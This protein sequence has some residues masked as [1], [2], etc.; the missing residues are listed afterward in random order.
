MVVCVSAV[1][2]GVLVAATE[3]IPQ[4]SD[5]ITVVNKGTQKEVRLDANL[6]IPDGGELL[7][8]IQ[9]PRERVVL[10]TNGPAKVARVYSDHVN[11]QFGVGEQINV[12]VE[13]TSAVDV[14]GTP[15]LFLN[16]GCRSS[17]CHVREVQRL[18]CRA[19]TGKFA[20]SFDGQRVTNIPWDASTTQFADYL[21]RMTKID[22]VLVVYRQQDGTACTYLGNNITVTFESMNIDGI[23]G[24]L[25]EMTADMSNRLGDG[26]VLGHVRF[27]PQLTTQA[28][29]IKKG[30]RVPNRVATF[31]GM[32]TP[33][34]LQF[35]YTILNGDN[36]TALEYDNTDA[37]SRSILAP[38]SA[39]RVFNAGSQIRAD[40][41][42]PPPRFSGDWERG[43]GS[44]LSA[45]SALQI[46][47]TPPYVT[48]VTSTQPD[49]TYGIGEVIIIQVVFS[50]PIVATGL[51]TIVLETGLVDRIVPFLRA[52]GATQNTLEFQYIVQSKDTSPDLTYTGT[53]ALQLNGG[54]IK[55][56]STTPT[57]DAV[58]TLPNNGERGSLS[59]SKNI[60]IDTTNPKI[61]GVS[62]LASDGTYTAG[63][64]IEI[65]V[66]FDS[67]VVVTGSPQLLLSTG[68][69]NLYPG[70]F[71]QEAPSRL[72]SKTIVF[73]TVDHGLSTAG[74]RGLQFLIDGQILTVDAVTGDAVTMLEDYTKT[75]VGP[76]VVGGPSVP[77]FTP[78]YR[79][80]TY[81]R[82]SGTSRLVF[83]YQV[84]RGDTS[85]DLDYLA[86]TSL[87][88]N[89]G[90]IKRLSTT[91]FTDVDLT[92]AAPGSTGSLGLSAA[93]VINTNA[94][95]VIQANLLTRD[96]VYRVGDEIL[97]S[98]VFDL[99]VVVDQ[100][101]SVRMNVVHPATERSAVYLSGSGTSALVFRF[102]CDPN[103]QATVFDIAD[104]TSLRASFGSIFGYIRRLAMNP[105]LPAVLNLPI[106]GLSSKGI[107]IDQ[108]CAFVNSVSVARADGAVGAGEIIQFTVQYSATVNVDITN[109][110][111]SL[112]L[113]TQRRATYLSGTGSQSLT[114]QYT[115]AVDDPTTR[116]N[117]AD[118][119]SLQLNG[120]QI[121]ATGTGKPASTVL[122]A[123]STS[124]LA[125]TSRITID[126]TTPVVL[127]VLT[128]TLDDVYTVGDRLIVVVRMNSPIDV[129]SSSGRGTLT[130][131]LQLGL[132][133]GVPAS[134]VS[135]EADRM[136]FAWTVSSG[137]S[138]MRLAYRSRTSLRCIGNYGL[139]TNAV[140]NNAITPHGVEYQGRL[141]VIWSERSS[142]VGGVAQLRARSTLISDTVAPLWQQE[143][144]DGVTSLIQFNAAMS[145][146]APMLVAFS[147]TK[148]YACW[149]ELS[150]PTANTPSQIRVAAYL[151]GDPT[152]TQ[153]WAFVDRQPATA[154]G[155]NLDTTQNAAAP[156]MVVHSG[157]LYVAWHEVSA[158]TTTTQIRV[159]VYGGQD[160]APTWTFV[161]GNLAARGLNYASTQN[162]QNV[163]L[164]SCNGALHAAWEEVNAAGVSQIRVAVQRGTDVSP[165]W[166]FMDG[167]SASGLNIAATQGANVP[168]LACLGDSSLAVAWHESV[169]VNAALKTRIR[170][171][172]TTT[173]ITATTFTWATVDGGNGLNVDASQ[174]GQNVR[175][176]VLSQLSGSVLY[177]SWEETE[178]TS[179][180][181]QT[182]DVFNKA[183]V[184][185]GQY[186]LAYGDDTTVCIDWNAA[187]TGTGSLQ[188]ALQSISG[189]SLQAT[190]TDDTN[191]FH[192]GVRYTITFT[193]PTT[194]LRA[195]RL[196]DTADAGCAAWT[197]QPGTALLACNSGTLVRV[198]ENKNIPL[199]S[200]IVDINVRFSTSVMVKTGIPRL[201]LE[202]GAVDQDAIYSIRGVLREFDVGTTSP[203]FVLRGA[204]RL[205]YGDVSA[206]INTLTTTECINIAF[207]NDDDAVQEIQSKLL[208]LPALRTIGLR[209][210]RR[211]I[212]RNGYRYSILFRSSA[213]LLDLVPVD[214]SACTPFAGRVQTI[215]V[216]ADTPII[217]GE[218]QILFGDGITGCVPVKANSQTIEDTISSMIPNRITPIQ[219]VK[220]PSAY[221]FGHR[222]FVSFMLLSDAVQ[223]LRVLIGGALCVPFLCDD[224]NG[225]AGTCSGLSITTNARYQAIRAE[226][227]TLSFRYVIQPADSQTPLTVRDST[228]LSGQ[229][230]RSSMNP[231]LAAAL[232]LPP[233]TP[234]PIEVISVQAIP[235]VTRVYSSTLN[236]VYTAGDMLVVLVEFSLPVDVIGKPFLELNSNGAAMFYSGS[237]TTTLEFRYKILPGE[238]T[239]DLNY[240]SIYSLRTPGRFIFIQATDGI[241]ARSSPIEADLTL[242][243]LTDA[244]SLG[245]QHQLVI[246][247]TTPSIVS[248][249][250]SRPDSPAGSTGY[251]VGD[252]IDLVVE[253]S[254]EISVSGLPSLALNSGGVATFTYGGYRQL[255]DIG[256]HAVYPVTSG[257][258]AVSYKGRT[259]G[260]ID[261]GDAQS[262]AITS[263]KSQLLTYDELRAIGITSVVMSTKK[264]GHRFEITFDST[265][266]L[267]VPEPVLPAS[268][269]VCA[270]LLPSSSDST[271]ERLLEQATDQ[272]AVFHYHVGEGNI[273]ADLDTTGVGVDL[274]LNPNSAIQR[275][276]RRP[277]ID[278]DVTLPV[279]GS[280]GSL[281]VRKT[282]KVDGSP[283]VI[284]DIISDTAGGTYGVS[285]PPIASPA[286]VFPGEILFHL[287]FSR[288]VKV[289]GSPTLELATGSLQSN[290]T[291][292]PNR[293]AR[294]VGQPQPDQ[295]AFLYHIQEGDFSANLAFASVNA[296]TNAQIYCVSTSSTTMAH[297]T[298]PRL[299]VSTTSTL[300]VDAQSVPTTVKL[301]ST[302]PNGVVGA[303]EAIPIQVT[304]SKQVILQTGLNRQQAS[305]ARYPCAVEFE[306]NLYVFWTEWTTLEMRPTTR[307]ALY[308]RVFDAAMQEVT[309]TARQQ[310]AMNRYSSSFI[311]KVT[312]TVWMGQ[313]Y[314]AWD[315]NGELLCTVFSGLTAAAGVAPWT[316]VPR[317]GAN[318][319]LAMRASDPQL[320]VHNGQLVMV[321]REEVALPVS[322]TI[323]GQ[324][325]MAQRNNDDYD[326]PLW[327][328]HDGNALQKG[329]NR[330]PLRDT[331]QPHAT[332]FRGSM[333]L[334]WNEYNA[335]NDAYELVIARRYVQNRDV[336]VWRFLDFS[337]SSSAESYISVYQPKLSVRRRGIEDA[338]LFVTWYRD[339]IDANVT[340]VVQGLIIETE[341]SETSPSKSFPTQIAAMR[342]TIGGSAM[343]PNARGPQVTACGDNLFATWVEERS[344]LD[345][346]SLLKVQST[347]VA[348][349]AQGK[350]FETGW[351]PVFR[352]ADVV[353]NHNTTF[354]TSE[355]SLIC[356]IATTPSTM[357]IVWTEFDGISMKLRFRHEAIPQRIEK[358][359]NVTWG[360]TQS[361]SPLLL[362]DT[363]TTPPGSAFL[364][365]RSGLQSHVLTFL[366]VVQPGETSLDLDV[367]NLQA[368]L[369]NGASVLDYL[370][371][372]PDFT[373]F[374]K[375]L[376]LRSLSYN[377][378][379][380]VDTTVPTVV[381]VTSTTVSGEYGVGERLVLQVTFSAPISVLL[382]AN[383]DPPALY[384]RA[385]EL[386]LHEMTDAAAIYN[387]GSTTTVLTFVY[388]TT[389]LDYCELL[390]YYRSD[391]LVY[392]GN[393][394]IRRR[395]TFPTT[396]ASL[397]LPTP[398][399]PHSLSSNRRISIKPTQPRVLDIT[400]PIPDGVYF[401]GDRIPLIV[402]FS[403]PVFVY[404]WPVLVLDTGDVLPSEARYTSG[405]GTTQL[406]FQ[407]DVDED[408]TSTDLEVIDD[409]QGDTALWY[410]QSL[411]LVRQSQIKRKATYPTTDAV[412]A[413][414]APG[415][416]GSL[417]RNM[418]LQIDSSPPKI[419]DLRSPTPDGTY[420]IGDTITFLVEFSHKVVVIGTPYLLL[421][422]Q[423]ERRRLAVYSS[424]SGTT[425]LQFLYTVQSGDMTGNTPLDTLNE[426][427]FLL[428]P[429]LMGQE[430]TQT[431]ASVLCKSMKPI[432]LA[433]LVMP[434][435]GVPLR[436][437]AVRSLVGNNQ[438]LFI[439][440][441][442]MRVDSIAVDVASGEVYSPGQRIVL[443]VQFTAAVI[444]QG[445]PRLK[446]NANA[447]PP[448]YATYLDGSGT[449]ILRFEYIVVAGD[450]V[451]VLDAASQRA[452]E[453]PDGAMITDTK[454]IYVPLRLGAM[455]Q[456]G[457]LSFSYRIEISSIPPRVER[458][459][460]VTR[461]G[462]YAVGDD[463]VVAVSFS[464]RVMLVT[465]LVQASWPNLLLQFVNGARVATYLSGDKSRSLLFTLRLTAGDAT[466][467][468]SFLDYTNANALVIPVNGLLAM[469]TTPTTA[470]NA[471]LPA[472][473]TPG[474]L[475]AS[476]KVRIIGTPPTVLA[477]DAQSRN[478]T[479]GLG[480][481]IH[482]RVRFSSRVVV[483]AASVA[484]CT[485]ELFVTGERIALARLVGGSATDTLVFTYRVT[486]G[487]RT[488]QL[489]Y[490]CSSS[491]SCGVLLFSANPS[492]A[493]DTTLPAPG[494]DNGLGFDDQLHVDFESPRVI[495]VSSSLSN[496][497]YGAG[498]VV[499]ITVSF[500]EPVAFNTMG[501]VPRL[502]LAIG[503]PRPRAPTYAMYLSGSGTSTFTMRYTTVQG[504]VA[505]PIAYDGIDAFSFT[506]PNCV[507][508][509]VVATNRQ[510]SW[511]L[512]TPGATGSLSNNRDIRIDTAE[513]PRVIRVTSPLADGV[514]TAGDTVRVSIDFTTPVVV[515]GTPFLKIDVGRG[516]SA[517]GIASYIS[518]SGS[519]TLVFAYLVQPGDHTGRL[520]YLPCPIAARQRSKRRELDK[521]VSCFP[522]YNALQVGPGGS[523]K[524]V[525]TLPTT[526]A[527]LD[528]PEVT[529]WPKQRVATSKG[530]IVYVNQL[531]DI[532]DLPPDE[533]KRLQATQP[534][535]S[536]FSITHQRTSV[537]IYSN[538]IP[539]HATGSF[540]PVQQRYFI[541]LRRFAR[542]EPNPLWIPDNYD[543]ILGVF[544]N[545]IG[546]KLSPT[547]VT[548]D[549]CGG[550]VDAQQRYYYASLP[551]CWLNTVLDSPR[552]FLQVGYAFDGHPIYYFYDESGNLPTLDA[553]HGSRGVDGAYRYHLVPPASP[554]SPPS[555]VFMPC[556]AG[557]NDASNTRDTS[558]M[559]VFRLPVD[560]RQVE[561]LSLASLSRFDGLVVDQN[562]VTPR[563]T[564]IWLNP[565][566]VSV[567]NTATYVIVRSN[568]IPNGFYGP[569]PNIY[570]KFKVLAQD[571]LFRLPRQPVVAAQV[572]RT[573]VDTPIAVMINGIPLF[574]SQSAIYGGDVMSSSNKAYVLRD[575][576]NGLVDGGGDYRYYGPPDCLLFE[577]SG[578]LDGAGKP[579]PLLGYA[580]DGFPIYG[581][582]TESGV[583]PTDLD[584][585]NG[586]IGDDGTYR[587]HVTPAKA[588]YVIGCFRGEPLGIP[589]V[590]ND[591]AFHS[592]SYANA[593]RIETT[594]PQII[595]V[596]TNKYPGVYVAGETL[597]FVVEWSVPVVVDVTGGV[598]TLALQD[599]PVSSLIARYDATQSTTRRSV[600]VVAIPTTA[601][602]ILS[603]AATIAGIDV[604]ARRLEFAFDYRTS[605]MV[606]G[607][608]IK[609]AA[610]VPT[611]LA[612]LRLVTA[613][614]NSRFASKHQ[615]AKHV[616][617]V[618]RGLYHPHASDLRVR[619][620]HDDRQARVLDGCCG[621]YD[622]GLPDAKWR[623]NLE[624]VDVYPTNPTSGVGWDYSFQD[625]PVTKNYARDGGATALQS[626]T[627]G[628]CDA[629]FAIDGQIRG[630]ISDQDVAQTQAL[631]NARSWWELRLV[632][633]MEIG[634]IRIWLPQSKRRDAVVQLLRV[635]SSDGI[636]QVDGSFTLAYTAPD[637]NIF[638]TSDISWKAVAM[639]KD[640]DARVTALGIGVGESLEAK[641]VAAMMKSSA[642]TLNVGRRPRLF[643]T[644]SPGDPLLSTNGAFTWSITFLDD[645]Q[646]N[647]SQLPPLAVATNTICGGLGAVTLSSPLPG[648]DHDRWTYETRDDRPQNAAAGHLSMFPFWV[649]IYEDTA[650]MAFETFQN[651]S[652]AAIWSTR[653]GPELSTSPVITLN[654]PVG[655]Q[656]T[657]FV[658]IVSEWP[659]SSLAIAEVEVLAERNHVM[660]QYPHGSPIVTEFYPGAETWSPEDSFNAAFGGLT[661]E[662]TWTLAI[663]DTTKGTERDHG[664]GAISDWVLYITNAAGKTRG[665]YMDIQAQIRT[666]PRHGNLYVPLNGTSADLLDQDRNTVLDL[667]EAQSYLSRNYL[668]YDVLPVE[669]RQRVLWN[670]VA[671]YSVNGGIE[672]LADNS[673]RQLIF[674][675]ICDRRCLVEKNH[676]DPYYY[677]GTTGDVGLKTLRITGDRVVRYVPNAGFEGIDAFTFSIAIGSQ[678]SSVRGTMELHVEKCQDPQCAIATALLHRERINPIIRRDPYIN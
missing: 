134:L 664:A 410:V 533:Q 44:S 116:L 648:D 113:T 381:D 574:S 591:V 494:T 123:P 230:F 644:R 143:D 157:K 60:V 200:G 431:P 323:V 653:V 219:V 7:L 221:T 166:V 283:V 269:D 458:V 586:R 155:I 207:E 320:L 517:P 570:N 636:Q 340:E 378:D 85:A 670:F 412:V 328:F 553:C 307:S 205:G 397:V 628:A 376:D 403:L 81:T 142:A 225:G 271:P 544:L 28:F 74:S 43:I 674:P 274:I 503:F 617:I 358:T 646:L 218:M 421:N 88:L 254:S 515:A 130:L 353:A 468:T 400:S 605:I 4:A 402:T 40:T 537:F 108:D 49:G 203:S 149:Q 75:V 53:T 582:Y 333:F 594:T 672:V 434:R 635:D 161:D 364:I 669:T 546:F 115:V 478:G 532:T 17:S 170:A 441:D 15:T 46:D 297:T 280:A 27:D 357:G 580:F 567:M 505:L 427:S 332:V 337:G 652:D 372:V 191:G 456:P 634:T 355:A 127:E 629:S 519:A 21:Q 627:N 384:L 454:G 318:K 343:T 404:G 554:S 56:K 467:S 439:R 620:F 506:D 414:P 180:K 363:G 411:R 509:A 420:D 502:R 347:R 639:V 641:I 146:T 96:G 499:D 370:G 176:R 104:P 469:A 612:N 630:R 618:M 538:G 584:A 512:P 38:G 103:D 429:L 525:A 496:G 423:A 566:G 247:T 231:T 296:L 69:V 534:I 276:A 521:L 451:A 549:D 136:Y 564:S 444:V 242:P 398:R 539:T 236:D 168:S 5:I 621:G 31:A 14:V 331:R 541:E 20:V 408:E 495:S 399:G 137:Q 257:Q 29:E 626:S 349:L 295:A 251:G 563:G 486:S 448:T 513:P 552:A 609:R 264:N 16:T 453:L 643:I 673:E 93:L 201:T 473:G 387:G 265:K 418:N 465:P 655:L 37:L 535:Q 32:A 561:S 422:V 575:K 507:I 671:G 562:P 50:F 334:A 470:I 80:A 492:L 77:I 193:F 614:R 413:V 658:R 243:L 604:V 666:L 92:L 588:P 129:S 42:L 107:S 212:R 314:A 489:D 153:R 382:D 416:P 483:P 95:R 298:L 150:A 39:I 474:S 396:D 30:R 109:G 260:C 392:N 316:V 235:T 6:Y 514:Y 187:S 640:E 366:Y 272:F 389:E 361:G 581:P 303:G 479:Y 536:E 25:P 601:L 524:R 83:T 45:N 322:G 319:N 36:A 528:L 326:A 128:P 590:S 409:R 342:T 388:V 248:V 23:D 197:C 339:T 112:L 300:K 68:S 263:L 501:C 267:E 656:T 133:S 226:T 425:I 54:S 379:I 645:P 94:P 336:S 667:V 213:D 63:D 610:A 22:K 182:I 159:V 577:L 555:S 395:A 437:N 250:S 405:N 417:S 223:S 430:I 638:A 192:D 206:G 177:A 497:I 651:A 120:G 288:A 156:H 198:N 551:T 557:I 41:T 367:I 99:S 285:F 447:L 377:N 565:E 67:P 369:L 558:L 480:D 593:I 140:A 623:M 530:G 148:V 139:T 677:E 261:Y 401:P 386:H 299:L 657:Q 542:H 292:L 163:R 3:P 183:S 622:F 560:L 660:S 76:T 360:E 462:T 57:T 338:D 208:A 606:N 58:L 346:G 51:P 70:A 616:R 189:L 19:T 419:I 500:S 526:E 291:F 204:F 365:D 287:V 436:V 321:W 79:P 233:V 241:V 258:F 312:S 119:Y 661:T 345:N 18:Q 171:K 98:V 498:Q 169:M 471:L 240:G 1:L 59:V 631:P 9:V 311:E 576:C 362:L 55:R 278:V 559:S 281:G 391:A 516:P 522:D 72:S 135:F 173:S 484:T 603:S 196:V 442:G 428:R 275:R 131:F 310:A 633:P 459:Y 190:V 305:H 597:D 571:Y 481:T 547:G 432:Q 329:L 172:M 89:G 234:Q 90:S 531:E 341:W 550:T 348:R 374:P 259:S 160:N 164:I 309:L 450:S 252:I 460:A 589:T 485:L 407:Y 445:L 491:L 545:G 440:T 86:T 239:A 315:E 508:Y 578:G 286:A 488:G 665:Y 273:A 33:R 13:F 487:D 132:V 24:D 48:T 350:S 110:R 452:L 301:S 476:S 649:F 510:A 73:P 390:D 668:S 619:L 464:R 227:E 34:T 596:Y 607:A 600:F 482:L 330:D 662:G 613:E 232:T 472:P 61:T 114:F 527:V 595:Q 327:I 147:A 145:A 82:G 216:H 174:S 214:A 8:K 394:K 84:Q 615:L 446:L 282:L 608:T 284:V 354:D 523:I 222:F 253:F 141:I 195:L 202:T 317:F 583:L 126:T 167:N 152:V 52:S 87:Q 255:L 229:I 181:S 215:D 511:R 270:P 625:F 268:T 573:P 122:P 47:V 256:V 65:Q 162:A 572:T 308:L 385:D 663:Q 351:Q 493:A 228:A 102:V 124:P 415:Y 371:Q 540:Q 654:P 293:L 11:G 466:T 106:A 676:L 477:V 592:L 138:T 179:G 587:Y 463:I 520:E 504:D 675:S 344:V 277:V 188:A 244:L 579:S 66:A 199:R 380:V 158:T 220:D 313:L 475:S 246:Q 406:T 100:A 304:F 659:S 433:I 650:L 111:P 125:T 224:G 598:P 12:F 543:G 210:V 602:E 375:A 217:Q 78:G 624:Q 642:V 438:K 10:D 237:G 368:L 585:C 209:D 356:S 26:T 647:K 185:Q 335:V 324:I 637:G 118:I 373:L 165:R 121:T 302:H 490:R 175:L 306:R 290:G 71:V 678:E 352:D 443:S 424:G 548:T 289:V 569:F 599:V 245:S 211:R 556:L 518:G 151:G 105:I 435:P 449:K 279:V 393:N 294:F 117:Y 101:A 461:D 359:S 529:T 184:T 238:A 97:F 154:L 2:N 457:S 632:K 91:P 611:L 426:A 35:T 186:K 455:Y 64:S 266:V 62:A 194:G 178:A 262:T 249:S 325:R 144:G 383:S 568:G